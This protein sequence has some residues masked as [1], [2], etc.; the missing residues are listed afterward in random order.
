MIYN[1]EEIVQFLDNTLDSP[2]KRHMVGGILF[3]VSLLFG[4]LAITILTVR[5]EKGQN[6][7]QY[8]E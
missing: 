5:I 7:E 6:D 2:R 3:S 4:G 1:L 8:V